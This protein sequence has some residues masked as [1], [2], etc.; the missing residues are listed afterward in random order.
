MTNKINWLSQN[1]FRSIVSLSVCVPANP[2]TREPHRQNK[3]RQD[4]RQQDNTRLT[5][6]DKPTFFSR[7]S[8]SRFA[9]PTTYESLPQSSDDED[10]VTLPEGPHLSLPED[11]FADLTLPPTP[12]L[13]F[14]VS[15]DSAGLLPVTVPQPFVPPLIPSPVPIPSLPSVLFSVLCRL[16]SL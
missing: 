1:S 3:I 14:H 9:F 4:I 16:L 15:Y 12:N 2:E 7:S 8:S 5:R 10:D 11:P 13:G 6:H